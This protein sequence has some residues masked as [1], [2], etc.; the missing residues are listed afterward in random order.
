[1]SDYTSI[2]AQLNLLDSQIDKNQKD[3]GDLTVISTATVTNVNALNGVVSFTLSKP[4]DGNDED[5]EVTKEDAYEQHHIKRKYRYEEGR[6]LVNELNENLTIRNKLYREDNK[7]NYLEDFDNWVI[8]DT[9]N[10][11]EED[12]DED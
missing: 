3:L 12:E 2:Q 8:Q 5:D 11:D 10:S 1:M 7:D 4:R 6:D 9:Y